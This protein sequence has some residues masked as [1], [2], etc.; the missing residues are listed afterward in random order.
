MLNSTPSR[1]VIWLHLQTVALLFCLAF[2]SSAAHADEQPTESGE[3]ETSEAASSGSSTSRLSVEELAASVRKSLVIVHS[4]GRDGRELGQGTGFVVDDSGLIATARHVIGSGRPVRVELS[5]GTSIPVTHVEASS[6]KLDLVVLRINNDSLPVL[7]LRDDESA[8]Q[9]QEV[10][11]MG[12][13]HGL[14][15]SIVAGVVSGTREVDNL[16]MLQLAMAIEPGNSGGPVVDRIGRVV[17]IVTMKSTASE[18]IGYAVPVQHLSE[19]LADP[20]P[21][22]MSRWMTIGALDSRQ[23]EILW[24]A[25]WR[26]RAGRINVDGYGTSFGGRSL[27]L[28]K[29]PAAEMPNEVQ[30]Q[31]KL[32][33]ERGAAG[34]AFHSDGGDR[35]YGFYPSAGNMRL[36]RFN[37]PDLGSW[38]ILHNEPHPAYKPDSWNTIKVRME[39][40]KF[41]CYLNDELVVTST[42]DVIPPGQIGLAVF[43]GTEASFRNFQSAKSLP[44]TKPDPS[45]I[46]ELNR[47]AEQIS[48][49]RPAPDEL[50]MEALPLQQHAGEYLRMRAE[51]LEAQ[52]KHARLLAA[53][54]RTRMIVGQLA[55]L[56]NK[57]KS[58]EAQESP[59][60]HSALLLA[61]LDNEEVDVESYVRRI[62]QMA[63]EIKSELTAESSESDRLAALNEYL[64]EQ[65]GFRGSRYE[66]YTR[67][68]S[69]LNEVIDDREGLPITLSV[70]YIEIAQRLDLNIVGVG[71]PGH[72]V[73]RFEPSSE[74]EESRL[75]DP[76]NKG[77]LIS[78]EEAEA[79]IRSRGYPVLPEFLEAKSARQ[80]TERML[81]NLLNLA[82]SGRKDEQVL[83][84]LEALVVVSPDS[85]EYRAKRLE[86]RARTGRLTEAI[87]DADWFIEESPEGTNADRLYELRAH[88]QS[89]LERQNNQP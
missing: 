82:E 68:N 64:F 35:H 4:T 10:V 44:P 48:S 25:N 3:P 79:T 26:Q 6:E 24:G 67:S 16:E 1:R 22:E 62:D 75:I 8:V 70:L 20:N 31:V 5:D 19:M 47:I 51:Q 72:F 86:I 50:V 2:W 73:V 7:P 76:F 38:T 53:Q 60:A 29:T 30:V 74:D 85:P 83:R 80:I 57:T 61:Q 55:E 66:Y 18:N 13:P 43:R 59:L 42:D 21:V 12:H 36:T 52:A 56:L 87:A 14:K 37:G 65:N 84:Y 39:D 17:G 89:E 63:A 41:A 81:L 88:L 15:N 33:D 49:K 54:V 34:L 32:N 69:Y 28:S 11:A 40:G 78:Q 77:Q 46:V 58:D 27:C 9:G 23:W 71:L 45:T